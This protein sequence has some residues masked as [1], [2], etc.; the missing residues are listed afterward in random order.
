MRF[1]NGSKRLQATLVVLGGLCLLGALTAWHWNEKKSLEEKFIQVHLATVVQGKQRE[2]ESLFANLY[3]NLRTIS[4]LPSVRNISGGNRANENEDMVAR[5]RFTSEGQQTV[6]QIY[7]NLH[8][9]DSVNASEVYAVLDGLDAGKGEVPFFMYDTMVFGEAKPHAPE[10]AAKGPDIPEEVEAAEYAYFPQ[11]MDLIKKSQP[12]FNFTDPSQ[13]PAF[14]SPLMRTCDNR[15]Y[16]SLSKGH[17]SDTFGMLY[18]LPFYDATSQRFRGVISGILRSN[19]LEAILI[20]TPLVPVTEADLA[21]QKQG[22]WEMPPPAHF[23]L[24]NSGYG[25]Q[26]MDRRS[27]DLPAQLERGVEGRNS[28]HIK[29]NIQSDTPWLLNYYLPDSLLETATNESDHRFAVL[30]VVVFFLV[31]VAL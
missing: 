22:A 30:I 10:P 29:L 12:V 26:I 31:F 27:A 8:Q 4:L 20:G 5:G 19:V 15:Q 6:Q 16:R 21:A 18:S 9:S 24:S 28:F 25:V 13:I 14:V 11:Q 7:N 23:L 3:R 2:L 17:V 1:S